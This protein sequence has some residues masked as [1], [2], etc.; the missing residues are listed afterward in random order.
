[1]TELQ[2]PY[3]SQLIDIDIEG[4][5][6]DLESKGRITSPKHDILRLALKNP[7]GTKKLSEIVSTKNAAK[8][9][10]VIDDH[11]RNAPTEEMLDAMTD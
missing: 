5:L 3:G 2:I 7:I 4:K 9:V 1:M 11:T 8:I 6:L 10:V